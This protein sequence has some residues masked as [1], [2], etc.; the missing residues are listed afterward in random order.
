MEVT[1]K[2]ESRKWWK[3]EKYSCI[4][5]KAS[6]LTVTKANTSIKSIS[7]VHETVKA[8]N[9][10]QPFSFTF[11]KPGVKNLSHND[12]EGLW[13]EQAIVEYLPKGL[14]SI[15]PGLVNLAVINCGLKEISRRDL[16]GL[17]A[18]ENL[19]LG[20][21][22][23]SALPNDLF[24]NM[25]KLQFVSLQDNKLEVV[26][27]RVL[28]PI[29]AN[30]EFANFKGNNPNMPVTTFEKGG[31][32]LIED[33]M[34]AIDD[35]FQPPAETRKV[36]ANAI[37]KN[38]RKLFISE[39][40]SDVIIK[41]DAG[42]IKAHK[43]ILGASSSVLEAAFN[44]A[45]GL[46]KSEIRIVDFSAG[47]VKDLIK[48]F[49]TGEVE[50]SENSMDLF[51]LAVKYDVPDLRTMCE[52]MI[53]ENIDELN[54]LEVFNLGHLH[55]SYPLKRA[56]F[57]QIESMLPGEKLDDRLINDPETLYDLVN[58]KRRFENLLHRCRQK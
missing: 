39:Q 17:E 30:I 45:D 48:F 23:L 11:S 28:E 2:F 29:M 36:N 20:Q 16:I 43:L 18:L 7:G 50:T 14:R 22:K 10:A 53:A 4:V 13:V 8:S 27:S 25:T 1:C 55:A 15:F 31:K 5:G 51:G 40:K 19:D 42:E 9:E 58:S 35:N 52:E 3:G 6:A 32:V 56:A 47:S 49:Y 12:V 37:V 34:K 41:T 44:R 54:A 46:R 38:L 21:N 57:A 26:S 24:V 33:L